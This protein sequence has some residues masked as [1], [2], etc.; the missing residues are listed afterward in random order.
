[1]SCIF[2]RGRAFSLRTARFSI[3]YIMKNNYFILDLVAEMLLPF[4]VLP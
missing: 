4:F 2:Y 1:M 3:E